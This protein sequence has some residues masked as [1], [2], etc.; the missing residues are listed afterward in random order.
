MS[1]A[2]QLA[3]S[4][5]SSSSS[6]SS[7]A[8]VV[9]IGSNNIIMNAATGI[10]DAS[11]STGAFV[12]PTGTTAQK[13]SNPSLGSLRWNTSNTAAEMYV[14]NSIWQIV[15]S[16]IYSIDYLIVAGGGSGGTDR[17]GGGGAV[18]VGDSVGKGLGDGLTGLQG[19]GG[20]Q[21]VVQGVGVAAVG[22]DVDL[23]V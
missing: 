22:G 12:I 13:P 19:I 17:G 21:R 23:A 8:N 18:V 3:Q 11:Y 5:S 4:L 6:A 10:I 16:S 9:S 2:Q 14:G 7:A 20:S 15:G 1:K